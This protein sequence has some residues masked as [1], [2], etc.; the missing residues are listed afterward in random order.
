MSK[1]YSKILVMNDCGVPLPDIE[2]YFQTRPC[3]VPVTNTE[4][5]ATIWG[6]DEATGVGPL[7]FHD[8]AGVYV[9]KSI[10]RLVQ[11]NNGDDPQWVIMEMRSYQP[12]QQDL[13]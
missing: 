6:D 5:I 4:G 10:A 12:P 9:N 11:F 1:A 13:S 7:H 2:V 8:P 3:L